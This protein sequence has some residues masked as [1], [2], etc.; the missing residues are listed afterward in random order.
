MDET[1]KRPLRVFL[2]HAKADKP[3]VRALYKRLVASEVDAWLDEEKLT[4]GQNWRIEIP[5]AVRK[6]DAVIICLSKDS[7]T[8]EGYVQ[9]EIKFALDIAKEKPINT[10]YIIPARLEDCEVPFEMADFQWVDLFFDG[11]SFENYEYEKLIRALQFRAERVRARPPTSP[12]NYTVSDFQTAEKAER[13]A[14]AKAKREVAEKTAREKAERKAVEKAALERAKGEVNEKVERDTIKNVA[15]SLLP[16]SKRSETAINPKVILGIIGVLLLGIF[17]FLGIPRLTNLLGEVAT[18]TISVVDVSK[19]PTTEITETPTKTVI[20][21]ATMTST[22]TVISTP[23]IGSTQISP[24]DGMVLNYV[25]EGSF[26]MGGTGICKYASTKDCSFDNTE[27]NS[28]I[29]NS[30]PQHS[31]YL[32]AYWIDKTEVTNEMYSLC[33]KAGACQS[34]QYTKSIKRS[35]YYDNPKYKNYPVLYVSWN[36]AKSYCEWSNRRLPT[37]AEWEKAARG[38]DARLYPWGNS[39]PTKGL[40]NYDNVIGDTTEAGSYPLG[41]SPFGALDMAGNVWEW[42]SDWYLSEYYSQSPSDNPKGLIQEMV[43]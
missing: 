2:C 25:P 23:K 21:T 1:Q 9:T 16:K 3:A 37:E 33:V 4:P 12:P 26:E 11:T 30:F 36:D 24:Q 28:A 8:K 41:A 15:T 38:T 19:T 7:V 22:Q 17:L 32:N 10:I 34:P 35:S 6:T 29:D 13:E 20:S 31:V 42:V 39:I 40:L 5:K 43:A 14:N 27:I 18:P